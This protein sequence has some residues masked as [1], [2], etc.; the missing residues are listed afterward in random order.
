MAQQK[1]QQHH[2]K[3]LDK[4]HEDMEKLTVRLI[5]YIA[6]LSPFC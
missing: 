1:V 5:S 4:M 2:Q 6:L 3:Q